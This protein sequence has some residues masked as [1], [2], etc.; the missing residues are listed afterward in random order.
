M[1]PGENNSTIVRFIMLNNP[2]MKTPNEEHY[3]VILK[4]SYYITDEMSGISYLAALSLYKSPNSSS[5]YVGSESFGT[6]GAIGLEIK[7]NVGSANEY[8]KYYATNVNIHIYISNNYAY[9]DNEDNIHIT[10][11][12]LDLDNSTTPYS[13]Y[14]SQGVSNSNY[15]VV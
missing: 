4:K 2:S 12:G 6:N 8:H 7:I 13:Y 1:I 5:Y 11:Y 9:W 15:E 3:K 14:L 10:M